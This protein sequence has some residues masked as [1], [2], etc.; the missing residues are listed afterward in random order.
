MINNKEQFPV[1][2]TTLN[3]VAKIY[4]EVAQQNSEY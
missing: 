4:K 3:T 2:T 1:K